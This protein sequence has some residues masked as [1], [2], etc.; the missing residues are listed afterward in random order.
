M[1]NTMKNRTEEK[2]RKRYFIFGGIE[3]M[4]PVLMSDRSFYAEACEVFA[5][6]WN[7]KDFLI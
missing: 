2:L 3:K 6:N 5:K 1:K 7:K 4:N